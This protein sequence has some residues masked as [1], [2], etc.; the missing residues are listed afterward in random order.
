M[1]NAVKSGLCRVTVIAPKTR[2]DLALPEDVPLADLAPVLLRYAGEHLADD[3]QEHGGW[4]LSRLGSAPL[5]GARTPLALEIRDG[6]QLYLT[7]RS[8]AAPEVVF[9]DVV[10]AIATANNERGGRWGPATSR[11]LA[12]SI[13]LCALVLGAAIAALAGPPQL[14]GALVGLGVGAVLVIAG[15]VLARALSDSRAGVLVALAALPYGFVGGLLVAADERSI[16][17]L[18]APHL[19]IAASVVLVYA[20]AAAV[21]VSDRA[22]IFLA[23]VVC[24][25]ALAVASGVTAL[26]GAGGEGAGA[27]VAA[28]TLA[29]TSAL[30][31]LAFRLAR[32]PMPTVPSGP[33]DLKADAE[34]VEGRRVLELSDTADR[35]LSGLLLATAVI[36]LGAVLFLVAAGGV[37]AWSLAGVL[38]LVLI[39]RARVFLG[40]SQRTPLLI[41]G[42]GGL[43]LLTV[44]LAA[45]A[46]D[47]LIRLTAVLGG[48]LTIAVICLVYA[49]SGR[50]ETR[51]TSPVLGRA[52]DII[53]VLLIVAIV[54]LTLAICG[55]YTWARAIA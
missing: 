11:R 16:G 15:T 19:L 34:S 47:P 38:A 32:L 6:E 35:Y 14:P 5:D 55:A 17:Q 2:I 26:L 8:A 29:V 31:L 37:L 43:G 50:S 53:E 44:G 46:P 51:R 33:E 42:F 20:V 39:I 27:L 49:L 9:D 21:G 23:V 10:D 28:A 40:A 48:V 54:P 13:A 52:L 3:G 45:A 4:V 24:A 22:E 1:A 41:A 30:P 12:V 25:V 18:A 36:V 7:P